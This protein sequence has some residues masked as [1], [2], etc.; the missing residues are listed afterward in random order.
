MAPLGQNC[1]T[2]VVRETDCLCS[3]PTAA[4]LELQA[5]GRS[6]R[7]VTG[8]IVLNEGFAADRVLVVCRG[9]IKVTASSP[10]GRLLLVRI[11]EPGMCWD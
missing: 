3:L 5:L 8:E 2:C 10:E 6:V 7:F 4:L 1:L 9:T 11:A